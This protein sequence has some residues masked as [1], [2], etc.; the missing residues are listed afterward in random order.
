MSLFASRIAVARVMARRAA[1]V[2]KRPIVSYLTN[3]PDKVSLK[4]SLPELEHKKNKIDKSWRG[5]LE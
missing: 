2:Q 1:P 4:S 5:I 3:Y